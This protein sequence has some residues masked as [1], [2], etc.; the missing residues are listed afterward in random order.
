MPVFS[1]SQDLLFPPVIYAEPDGLLAVGGDLSLDR[2]LLAYNSGIFPWY[3]PPS[4][5][6][7]WSPD[8]RFIVFPEHV[9]VSKSMKQV[10]RKG[11]FQIRFDTAFS[12]VIQQCK[13]VARKGQEGT[14]ITPEMQ[15]AYIHLHKMGYAHSVEAWKNGSLVG[16]LYGVAIGRCFFGESMFALESNASKTAFI[17]LSRAL[18]E[19]EYKLID[20]QVHTDHLESLGAEFIS[21]ETFLDFLDDNKNLP[22]DQGSWTDWKLRDEGRK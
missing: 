2:L 12:Q 16:G 20:C 4:P 10:F 13:T 22:T 5:I 7:W 18:E 21:R 6:L 19:R 17:A 14:W 3:S 11:I 9:Y 8:P 15:E 1:L